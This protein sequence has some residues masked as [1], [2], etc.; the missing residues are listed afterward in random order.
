LV[1]QPIGIENPALLRE[2]DLAEAISAC[3]AAVT[4]DPAFTSARA[5][6]GLAL[7]ISG[8]DKAGIEALGPLKA[9]EGYEPWYWVARFW[10]VTRF[11][12][13]EAGAA[14]LREAIA[15]LPGFLMARGYL[16][17]L[18]NVLGQEPEALA[19][20]TDFL[21]VAP[22]S[23][24]VIARVGKT[25]ARLGKHAEALEKT[26]EALKLDKESLELQLQL[27]SRLIDANQLAPAIEALTPLA[28][29]ATARPEVLVRLGFAHLQLGQLDLAE[30]PLRR[31]LAAA[32]EPGEWRVRGRANYD[33]AL[34]A[35]KKNAPDKAQA[36][37][38]ES[39]REGFKPRQIDAELK[40]LAAKS[41]A[42]ALKAPKPAGAPLAPK[43]T[44]T[45]LPREASPFAVD[46]SGELDLAR[47]KPPPPQ[48][49][50]ILKFG[51]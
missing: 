13:N 21:S 8:D 43:L 51:K 11:Q 31:A 38:L 15:K 49:F 4:A 42:D 1:R 22:T 44:L 48:G 34:W 5:A 23:P 19:A 26:R 46:P 10:L 39:M 47:P 7:A 18:L 36:F 20:W 17:E 33:L 3:R 28:K 24:F 16:G 25:L 14:V 9:G 37:L 12:S 29:P 50:E 45:A 40:A 30:P 41:E 27:A 6:L 35:V 2:A 32:K